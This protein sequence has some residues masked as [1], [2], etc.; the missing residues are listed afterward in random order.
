MRAKIAIATLLILLMMI[1]LFTPMAMATNEYIDFA[2]E[3]TAGR[4]NMEQYDLVLRISPF[5]DIHANDWFFDAVTYIA[6]RG[7]VQGVS[8]GKFDPDGTMNRAMAAT[9]IYRLAAG[10]PEAEFTQSFYDVQ[11]GRWYTIPISWAAQTGI[12]YGVGNGRFNPSENM[13]REEFVLVLYRFYIHGNEPPLLSKNPNLHYFWDYDSLSDWSREAMMWAF[14]HWIILGTDQHYLL[15]GNAISRAEASTILYRFLTEDRCAPQIMKQPPPRPEPPMIEPEPQPPAPHPTRPFHTDRQR[16]PGRDWST[17]EVNALARNGWGEARG[18]SWEEMLMVHH[19]VFNRVMVN[20]SGANAYRNSIL[21]V[22]RQPGQFHGYRSTHPLIPWIVDSAIY[23]L[24]RWAYGYAGPVN[25]HAIN[26]N[27]YYLYFH[28]DGI[29][30]WFRSGRYSYRLQNQIIRSQNV[31]YDCA[32]NY[33][34][35]RDDAPWW[36]IYYENGV[37]LHTIVIDPPA[38]M[39]TFVR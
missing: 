32:Y 26:G 8:S 23:A 34:W 5:Y 38:N 29:H 19:T 2:I 10:E 31:G 33:I 25:R 9:M 24:Y 12:V 30:N 28:G 17:A 22:I 20:W 15:P 14:Y 1:S 27:P 16:I 37:D 6:E 7:I 35:H 4:N 21:G 18:T 11:H 39:P 13:T 3:T 36:Y